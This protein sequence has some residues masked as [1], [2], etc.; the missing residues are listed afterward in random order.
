MADEVVIDASVA[1]GWF[2]VTPDDDAKYC[3]SI[4]ESIIYG[5]IRPIV[6]D[7]FQIETAHALLKMHR[8][9]K[10]RFTV[11]DLKEAA[12]VLESIPWTYATMGIGHRKIIDLALKR[13]LQGYDSAYFELAISQRMPLATLDKG[14]V[15]ACRNFKVELFKPI[16]T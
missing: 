12:N 11:A 5:E 14:L 13:N 8:R 16:E 2:A 7:F 6:P 1:V 3:A 10:D 15:S 9:N 4:L